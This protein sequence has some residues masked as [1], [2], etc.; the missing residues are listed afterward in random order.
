MP[1]LHARVGASGLSRTLRCPG[2]VYLS[3]LV[4]DTRDNEAAAEGTAAHRVAEMCLE[5]GLDPIDYLGHTLKADG[6]EFEVTHEM[7]NALTPGIEWVRERAEAKDAELVVEMTVEAGD[8]MPGQFG[9]LDSGIITPKLIIIRDL[10]YGK[11]VPVGAELNDQQRAYALWFYERYAKHRT[12]AKRVLLVI[13]QPRVEGGW[14][15]WETTVSHLMDYKEELRDSFDLIFLPE[16]RVGPVEDWIVNPD[17]PLQAGEKQC[18]FCKAT[19]FCAEFARHNLEHA[20]ATF[21]DLDE[22]VESGHFTLRD[23][24]TF[25]PE[26]R[27]FVAKNA[28]M[29]RKWLNSVTAYTLAEAL[30]GAETPGLKAVEGRK[31]AKRWR[32]PQEAR[33]WLLKH[34]VASKDLYK[35]REMVSPTQAEELIPKAQHPDM[36]FLWVQDPGKPSLAD[37]TSKKAAITTADK[38]EDLDDDEFDLD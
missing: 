12:K 17:A 4:E 8:E 31:G 2:S 37:E 7:V 10:K 21:D 18:M 1:A 36:E 35:P 11:G 25:T 14:T 32:D 20:M 30:R 15:E 33:K 16:D 29:F 28:E 23:A 9:T 13:D 3:E 26:Q 6:F 34:G 38:F 24:D 22:M 27:S 5:F 19:G